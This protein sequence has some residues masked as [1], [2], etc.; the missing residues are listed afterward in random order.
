MK[1]RIKVKLGDP[2]RA[3]DEVE[4]YKAQLREK[5]RVFLGR[6]SELGVLTVRTM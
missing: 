3:V 6:L 1:K 5:C 4:Q 2:G